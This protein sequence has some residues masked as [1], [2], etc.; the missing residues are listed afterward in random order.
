MFKFELST[1]F[2]LD[3]YDVFVPKRWTHFCLAYDHSRSHITM[4]KVRYYAA[5]N[6]RIVLSD[7]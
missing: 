1:N 2:L 7:G 3:R 6:K 5:T 4:A